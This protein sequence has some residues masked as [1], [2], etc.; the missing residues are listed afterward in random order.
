MKYFEFRGTISG[1]TYLLRNL[2]A[3]IFAYCGGYLIGWGIGTSESFYTVLG[4]AVLAPALWFNMC[5]IYKR[6]NALYPDNANLITIT[7]IA[8]QVI[9]QSLPVL[10]IG[11]LVL[12]LILLL[13]NSKI[14]DH[15]G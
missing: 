7:M 11:L 5:T 15:N 6:S 4:M 12:G 10:N 8:G 1:T 3:T 2:M 13:K 9:A 14:D